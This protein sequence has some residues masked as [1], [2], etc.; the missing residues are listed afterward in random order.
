MQI[1]ARLAALGLTL[2]APL[3]TPPGLAVPFTWVRIQGGLALGGAHR[4]G[5]P[6]AGLGGADDGVA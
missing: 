5:V 3:Q 4:V 6:G 1:E 2:P